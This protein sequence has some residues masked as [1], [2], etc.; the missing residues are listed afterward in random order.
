MPIT[1][2]QFEWGVDAEIEEWM[3]KISAFL[4]QHK[5]QA[6]TSAEL[7][8]TIYAKP[9]WQTTV[10]EAFD[11]ALE[12][13]VSIGEAERRKIRDIEYYIHAEEKVPF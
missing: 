12:K 9:V 10:Q 6:F 8:K 3:G 7:W 11:E 1:R 5:D 4:A 13:L 2:K